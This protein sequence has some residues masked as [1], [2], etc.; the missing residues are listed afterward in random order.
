[1]K[2]PHKGIKR[3]FYATGHAFKGMTATWK[4]E[5]AFRQELVLLILLSP[6]AIWLSDTYIEASLLIGVL[7]VV[8]IV[9]ILNSAIETTIDRIGKDFHKLSGRAKDQASGAVF[10]SLLLAVLVW[11]G[12]LL[13]KFL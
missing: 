12:F 1:M 5:A 9:E 13:D 4:T 10:L 2:S 3:V 8:V 6:V 11:G 7:L